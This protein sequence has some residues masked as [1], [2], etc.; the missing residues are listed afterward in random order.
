[1]KK[2]IEN[3][4]KQAKSEAMKSSL[5][6]LGAVG[7]L[8]LAKAVKKF[9]AD[10]PSLDAIAKY[11]V[12]ALLAGGGFIL[13]SATDEKSNAKYLGYGLATAGV[14]DGLRII[15]VAKEWLSGV[16][17]EVEIPAA[18]AFYTES[19]E[20]Q[21]LINGFGLGDLPVGNASMQEVQ[22]MGVTLPD[23]DG[24]GFN[25]SIM[26]GLGYN[27]DQTDMGYNAS[28]TDDDIK[29]IL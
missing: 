13:A 20:R 7:G 27:A 8:V 10:R 11:G 24:L 15:P 26:E 2:Q 19:E 29:G 3:I 22:G 17:G 9:T 1:M 16:L 5:V 18:S 21:K 12:P 25:P 4:K 6:I 14:I 23:L 28:Q